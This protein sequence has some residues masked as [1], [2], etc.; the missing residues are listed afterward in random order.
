MIPFFNLKNLNISHR[1]ELLNAVQ[2][3]VDSGWYILGKHLENFEKEFAKYCR[4]KEAIGVG[5]GLDALT[6]IFRA[7]KELGIMREGDE[8]IVPANTYIASILAIT[9]NRLKPVLVEPDIN[10]YNIDGNLLEKHITQKT[11]AILIVHLYGQVAYSDKIKKTASK[12]KLKIVEDCAQAHGAEYKGRK[13]GSLGDAAGFSFY[14]SKPLGALGDA[15]AI[16]T[17]D[18][19]LAEIIHALRN[20]GS[21]KKYFN[22]YM[23][24]N[25]RL[26]ELQAAILSVKLKHLDKDNDKRRK[27]AELYLNNI[28]NEKLILPKTSDD[29]SHVWHVFVVRTKNRDKFQRH[30]LNNGI[31]TLIHYPMPPHKQKAFKEWRNKK[32]PITE[33]IHNT[34]ISLPLYPTMTQKQIW[35]VIKACNA[36]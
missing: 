7:Y 33:K 29:K 4:V 18:K 12:Y 5:N 32:Y 3:V 24:V 30:L 14:P 13:V 6:L 9:E 23:G 27:T 20:Y 2:K 22:D 17:N 34:I 31:E 19:K 21:H 28:K 36:F 15:G 25:S 10:T 11:K 8:I 26:D 1:K 35:Q 16:S